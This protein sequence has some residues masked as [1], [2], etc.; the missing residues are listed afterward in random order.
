MKPFIIRL[1]AKQYKRW[2]LLARSRAGRLPAQPRGTAAHPGTGDRPVAAI[3]DR[4]RDGRRDHR[5]TGRLGQ[6]AARGRSF[7]PLAGSG[8][9]RRRG[10]RRRGTDRADAIS[11]FGLDP[12]QHGIVVPR[13][14]SRAKLNPPGQSARSAGLRQSAG[15]PSER[16]FG[17][18]GTLRRTAQGVC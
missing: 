8:A 16:R 2:A 17:V 12:G 6:R 18:P 7:W 15:W 14:R 4:R 9:C 11:E 3:P 5:G 13:C 10:R 1:V